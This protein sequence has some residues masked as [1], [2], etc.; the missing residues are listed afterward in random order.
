PPAPDVPDDNDFQPV[1][2][3]LGSGGTPGD[4]AVYDD[5]TGVRRL[6]VATPGLSQVSII[7]T[8][9]AEARS[10]A[11]D[12]PVDRIL[13][14]PEGAPSIAVLASLGTHG[15]RIHLLHLDGLGDPM[16]RPQVD[17]VTLAR[18][19]SDVIAIP[20]QQRVLVIHDD[21]RTVLGVLDIREGAVS[22]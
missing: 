10:V 2:G 6:V 14:V 1:L 3:E 7:Q 9:T 5:P 16:Q 17:E 12:D 18:P 20:G 21:A 13:L 22:P 8:D 15:S 11:A 19:I 4:L